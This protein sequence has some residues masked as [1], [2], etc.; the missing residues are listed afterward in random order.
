M[1]P[2][3]AGFRQKEGHMTQIKVEKNV[4]VPIVAKISRFPFADMKIGDSFFV[5]DMRTSAEMSSAIQN[6][7]RSLKF[8]FMCRRVTEDGVAVGVRVWR[9]A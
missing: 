3:K 9:T 6:A 5:P 1:P 4:P 7:K 8:K 2:E